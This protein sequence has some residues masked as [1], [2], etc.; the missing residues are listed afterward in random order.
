MIE[1]VSVF[2]SF[3][4][5]VYGVIW[6]CHA[7]AWWSARTPRSGYLIVAVFVLYVIARN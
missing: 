2:V 1:Q 3:A 7:I 5:L 6:A 4:A